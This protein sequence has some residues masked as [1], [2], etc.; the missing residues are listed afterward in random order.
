MNTPKRYSK[1]GL[2]RLFLVCAFPTHVWTIILVLRDF[3]WLTERTNAWDAVGV[4]AYGMI[5]A[6]FEAG[7][8]FAT[9]VLLGFLLPKGWEEEKRISLLSTAILIISVWAILGQLYFLWG[10]SVPEGV[11]HALAGQAHPLR[12]LYAAVFVLVVPTVLPPLYLI[13]RSERARRFAGELFDRLA[14][15][16]GLYLILD[17]LGLVIIITRN[18]HA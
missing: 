2:W 9:V 15:L 1:Q 18:L 17:L 3:S 4:A 12:I 5:F 8:L 16:T 7:L 14:L 10:I 13:F 6:L 11:M